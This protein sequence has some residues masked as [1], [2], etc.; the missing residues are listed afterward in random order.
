MMAIGP[1][2]VLEL[3]PAQ[4]RVAARN[5]NGDIPD[6]YWPPAPAR[7]KPIPSGYPRKQTGKKFIPYPHPIGN[8]Y[9]T[10]IP[11]PKIY[12]SSTEI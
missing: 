7:S 9:P 11:Y 5:G 10:G 8:S 2:H 1:T 4:A 6:G 12:P 3:V